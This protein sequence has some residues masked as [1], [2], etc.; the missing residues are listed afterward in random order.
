MVYTLQTKNKLVLVFIKIQYCVGKKT[1]FFW[2][3]NS[4]LIVF[5]ILYIKSRLIA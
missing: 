2:F 3:S 5:R 1:F 4:F